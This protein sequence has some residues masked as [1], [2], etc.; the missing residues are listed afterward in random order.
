LWR[1]H[2]ARAEGKSFTEP[3]KLSAMPGIRKAYLG[4]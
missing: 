3:E 4:L 2:S 1:E